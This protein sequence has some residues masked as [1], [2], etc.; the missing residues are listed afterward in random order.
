MTAT[1]PAALFEPSVMVPLQNIE[2][3]PGS[4]LIIRNVPWEQFES[5]LESLEEQHVYRIAYYRGT[6]EIMS[7]LPGHE[8]PHRMIGDL[9]KAILDSEERDWE[10]FGST[11]F[12]NQSK[13]A[14]LEP[15]T[16]LYVDGNAQ[17]VRDCMSQMDLGQYPPPDLAIESD[18]TSKTTLEAYA[19]LGMPEVWVYRNAQL[20]IY[21][22]QEGQYVGSDVSQVFP[23]LPILQLI[24]QWVKRGLTEGAGKVLRE[25]RKQHWNEKTGN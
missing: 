23:T 5:I 17:L 8:R 1:T 4:P 14:G 6:L 3:V 11:T 9:V 10:D 15:D 20:V 19:A 2:L 21:L 13:A 12:R 18:V 22:L 7:P 16:C 25:F 24:P